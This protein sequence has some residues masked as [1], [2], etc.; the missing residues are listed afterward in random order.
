MSSPVKQYNLPWNQHDQYWISLFAKSPLAAH[1]QL[2]L[3]QIGFKSDPHGMTVQTGK[4]WKPVW[5]DAYS[6]ISGASCEEAIEVSITHGDAPSSSRATAEYR[7]PQQIQAIAQSLWL[8]QALLDDTIMCYL[9]PVLSSRDQ[10]FGYESF[11]R[12]RTADG[13]IVDGRAVM[14]ASKAL[15]IEYTV[16]R[17]LHVQAIMTFVLSNFTGFLFVNLFPGFIQ[18]PAVYLEGL[19]ETVKNF[20][21]IPKH[22]VLDFTRAETARD[23]GHLKSVCDYARSKG[24]SIALDDIESMEGARKLVPEIKPDFVKIDMNLVRVAGAQGKREIISNIVEIS[25]A[26]GASVIA[27]G[28]ETEATHQQLRSLGVDLFQGYLFSPP[29][30]VEAVV[31]KSVNG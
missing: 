11:A 15:G 1:V 31:K 7:T 10:V 17:H 30:P 16:D 29:I 27:E 18:R 21:V 24:Y 9:Q 5:D 26:A 23:L 13:N 2:S 6:V 3:Q 8:G 14:D 12:A 20:G 19:G 4:E 22:I 28:V 25:H